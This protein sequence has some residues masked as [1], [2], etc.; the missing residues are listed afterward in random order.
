MGTTEEW[1]RHHKNLSENGV[2]VS[3]ELLHLMTPCAT[4]TVTNSIKALA[5]P[6]GGTVP[7]EQSTK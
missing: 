3:N 7:P 4:S 6:E 1:A 2:S 5:L